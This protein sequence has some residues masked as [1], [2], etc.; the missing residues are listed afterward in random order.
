MMNYD[1]FAIK[2]AKANPL[3]N[4]DYLIVTDRQRGLTLNQIGIKYSMSSQNVLKIL[5]KVVT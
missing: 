4:R 3:F 2:Y 1:E 5:K